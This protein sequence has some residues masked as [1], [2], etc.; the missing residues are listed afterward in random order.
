MSV[1]HVGAARATLL[2]DCEP[3]EDASWMVT[4]EGIT[5]IGPVH[6]ALAA[7]ARLVRTHLVE[8]A[9]S[10]TCSTRK[11]E[12]GVT[13]AKPATA[14]RMTPVRCDTTLRSLPAVDAD[15]HRDKGR[16]NVLEAWEAKLYWPEA[17]EQRT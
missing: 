13:F 12:P 7:P 11:H 16:E 2:G 8:A 1:A 17:R 9:G 4:E 6:I 15:R 3:E 14:H 10:R 5:G